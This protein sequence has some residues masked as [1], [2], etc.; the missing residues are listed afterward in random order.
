MFLSIRISCQTFCISLEISFRVK[1]ESSENWC[2]GLFAFNAT[3]VF[4]PQSK[5]PQ[6]WE[7][8]TMQ[9]R[10]DAALTSVEDHPKPEK[11]LE[12]NE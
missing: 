4:L 5:L 11:C 3:A 7:K 10:L 9:H 12:K 6:M 8:H 2:I 1:S